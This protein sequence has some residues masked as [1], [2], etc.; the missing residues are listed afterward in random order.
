MESSSV[1][2]NFYKK[3]SLRIG[4]FI[5]TVSATPLTRA[6][7]KVG[8]GAAAILCVSRQEPP[9]PPAPRHGICYI[10]TWGQRAPPLAV[11]PP[12]EYG[13]PSLKPMNHKRN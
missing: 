9:S 8:P 6:A 11:L 12:H 5:K 1:F 10:R 3:Y 4:A 13:E 7:G 2:N